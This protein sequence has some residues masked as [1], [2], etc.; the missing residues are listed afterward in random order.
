M[1]ALRA[2]TTLVATALALAATGAVLASPAQAAALSRF[3]NGSFEYPLAPANSF[4][5]HAAGSSLGPWRVGAGGIDLIDNGFWQ[6]AEGDQSIDLNAGSPGS[7]AQTFTTVPGKTYTVSYSLAGNPEGVNQPVV[8]TGR[9]LIDGQ[10]FQ[11][12]TFDV[13]GKTRANMGYVNRQFTFTAGAAATTLG[14]VSSTTGAHG[15]V[16]DNVQV[17]LGCCG[18]SSSC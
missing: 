15:P 5:T 7:V 11:D 16:L 10:N 1:S 18:C 6:A 8:K 9:A 2:R 13:T 14:F 4:S 17:K 12:F 3:D